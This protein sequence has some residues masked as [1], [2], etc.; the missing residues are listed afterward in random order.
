MDP[1]PE[2]ERGTA[3]RES[4]VQSVRVPDHGEALWRLLREFDA[5]AAEHAGALGDHEATTFKASDTS[6]V[7]GQEYVTFG[8]VALK[9][10]MYHP[11]SLH[12]HNM[13]G[14]LEPCISAWRYF[15]FASS[16][17]L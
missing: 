6:L 7:P 1:V 9:A 15:S 11:S 4:L 14:P 13:R 17:L 10:V 2:D 3:V 5:Y 16:P 8:Q 12:Q